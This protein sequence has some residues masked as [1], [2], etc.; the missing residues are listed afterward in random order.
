M[1]LSLFVGKDKGDHPEKRPTPTTP[2]PH[3]GPARNVMRTD[4]ANYDGNDQL[5]NG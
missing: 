2:K 1:Y 5:R 3:T 4:G